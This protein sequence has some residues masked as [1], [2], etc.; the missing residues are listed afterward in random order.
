MLVERTVRVSDDPVVELFVAERD[1]NAGD[2]PLLILHGGPDWDHSYLREPLLQLGAGWRPVFVDLRGCGRSTKGLAHIDYTPVAATADL[3]ALLDVLELDQVDVLGFSYGGLLAQRLAVTAPER[4]RRLIIASSSVLPVPPDAFRGWTERD[5]RLAAQ[6]A[7]VEE[8]SQTC[9]AAAT[10]ADAV[11]SAPANVWRAAA[12]LGYLRR[13]QD[14]RFSAEW[15]KAWLAGPLPPARP[16]QGVERL[17]ALGKPILL[18]HGRQDMTFP[19]ALVEPTL[20]LLP[21]ARA[22]I[23]EEAGHMA[24]ID[25]P[26][27]W[28]AALQTFLDAPV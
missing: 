25:Q 1:Q 20:A 9:T 15:S 6:P 21:S 2:R 12:L 26:A 28:L 17:R 24:H 3:V 8:D 11:A 13:L 7:R 18:L 5:A 22:A 4:I 27:A 23:L 16:D 14:V 19:V 10:R